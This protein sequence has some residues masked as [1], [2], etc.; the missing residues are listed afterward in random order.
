M[1]GLFSIGLSGKIQEVVL[2][3][4]LLVSCI[5]RLGRVLS[6][7]LTIIKSLTC[8]KGT[9]VLSDCE[10]NQYTSPCHLLSAIYRFPSHS[11]L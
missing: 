5:E 2:G 10:G 7:V 3:G 6:R 4:S 1:R 11:N 9:G 8:G